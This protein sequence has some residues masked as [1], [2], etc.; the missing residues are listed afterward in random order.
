M[1]GTIFGFGESLKK[2]RGMRSQREMASLIHCPQQSYSEWERGK[3]L[4][5]VYVLYM[6]CNTFQCSADEVLGLNGKCVKPGSAVVEVEK[7]KAQIE[8]QKKV[9]DSQR[10]LIEAMGK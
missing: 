9:I 8:A 1:K 6:I 3:K 4:P 5:N 2:L 10:E 7:L